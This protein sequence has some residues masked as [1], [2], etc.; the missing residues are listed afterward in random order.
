[1]KLSVLAFAFAV[2]ACIAVDGAAQIPLPPDESRTIG[3][4]VPDVTLTDDHGVEFRL[5]ELAGRPLFLS[6]IFTACPGACIAITS[7][8]RD[9]VTSVGTV[10]TDF[11]VLTISFDPKD[12]VDDMHGYREREGL[13]DAW[14]LAVAQPNDRMKLLD[15]ID[16]R[17]VTLE[18]GGFDHV[19]VVAVLDKNLAVSGYLHGTYNTAEAVAAA[20]DVAKG[21]RNRGNLLFLI[22]VAGLVVT[23]VIAISL[24]TRRRMKLARS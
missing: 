3:R 6:P 5:S 21:A 4:V 15:A 9:A 12:S 22:G 16:F 17:F 7:S 8:L 19:N 18:E 11:N 14:R 1:M 2:I 20:L 24:I 10:G 23:A 13:P